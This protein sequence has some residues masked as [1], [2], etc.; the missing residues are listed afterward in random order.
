MGWVG[1]FTVVAFAA[2]CGYTIWDLYRAT[3]APVAEGRVPQSL[4]GL[5]QK[6]LQEI[7]DVLVNKI[8]VSRL[9]SSI[10][11]VSRAFFCNSMWLLFCWCYYWRSCRILG[12]S[13]ESRKGAIGMTTGQS[14]SYL[15]SPP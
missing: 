3:S 15:A 9:G 6:E 10:H 14:C 2:Y 8:A 7:P 5:S 4:A 13:N 1:R 11:A 12:S